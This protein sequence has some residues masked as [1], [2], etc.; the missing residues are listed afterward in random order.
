M[1]YIS[2]LLVFAFLSLA[3]IGCKNQIVDK[4]TAMLDSLIEVVEANKEVAAAIDIQKLGK[5]LSVYDSYFEF[6]Q[7]EYEQI[8]SLKYFLREIDQM[9]TCRKNA[10]KTHA[11]LPQWKEELDKTAVQLK[12]LKHDYENELISIDEF[13]AHFNTEFYASFEINQEFQKRAGATA[14]CMR[15]FKELTDKLDSTRQVFLSKHE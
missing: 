4:N 2:A 3:A 1:K 7:T 10:Q 11:Q 6:Y 14:M 8:D 9:A 15:T 13:E 12:A 5:M